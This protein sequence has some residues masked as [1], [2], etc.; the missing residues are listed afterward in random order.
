MWQR[1]G[2]GWLAGALRAAR[3]S[4]GP[5]PERLGE[6]PQREQVPPRAHGQNGA[7]PG[8]RSGN[9]RRT[10]PSPSGPASPQLRRVLAQVLRGAW[11][12]ARTPCR[13]ASAAQVLFSPR[14]EVNPLYCDTVKQ[15]YPH[16]SSGRLL[17]IIDMA[18]FDFLT[19]GC[20]PRGPAGRGPCGLGHRPQ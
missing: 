7:Q 9:A 11:M 17:N 10:G 5:A 18:I 15:V 2:R 19:G 1:N 8:G 14:W 12:R 4:G 13:P 20:C 3:E 16:S 6:G